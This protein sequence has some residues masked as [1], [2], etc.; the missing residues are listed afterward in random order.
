LIKRF[1]VAFNKTGAIALV[2]AVIAAPVVRSP[3]VAIIVTPFAPAEVIAPVPV[4]AVA[5]TETEP[6]AFNVPAPV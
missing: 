4:N 2:L 3:A 5:V 1:A 6:F